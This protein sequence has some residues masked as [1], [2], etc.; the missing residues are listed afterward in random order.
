MK[1]FEGKQGEL[2]YKQG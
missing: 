2:M 1:V